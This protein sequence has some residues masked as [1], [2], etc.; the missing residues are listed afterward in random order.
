M[1][2][3]LIGLAKALKDILTDQKYW[4]DKA[5]L[6]KA[7]GNDEQARYCEIRMDTCQDNAIVLKERVRYAKEEVEKKLPELS[8]AM[9]E[10]KEAERALK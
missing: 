4:A 3:G 2:D 9:A 6:A 1:I 7:S 10:L 5:A 8:K